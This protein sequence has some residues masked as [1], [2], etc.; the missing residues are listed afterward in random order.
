MNMWA[1][2]GRPFGIVKEPTI[3]KMVSNPGAKGLNVIAYGFRR[4]LIGNIPII[5]Q[6][7][8]LNP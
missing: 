6:G 7:D 8:N 3:G 5:T 1:G 2:L 4:E